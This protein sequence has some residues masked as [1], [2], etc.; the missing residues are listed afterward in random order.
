M[1]VVLIVFLVFE[2]NLCVLIVSFFFIVLFVRILILSFNLL[3]MLVFS[4]NLGVIFVLFLKWFNVDK[5][6]IVNFLWLMFVKLCFGK[7]R[8]NGVWLFLKLRWILLLECVFCF[9][10]FLL[11]VLLLLEL[12]L[13]LIWLCIL[14]EFFVGFNLWSFIFRYFFI[15]MSYF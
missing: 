12:I 5:F 8:N 14:W 15:L 7:W 9:L 13:W 2:E 10:W 4:N 3:I 6:I 11:V 1:L